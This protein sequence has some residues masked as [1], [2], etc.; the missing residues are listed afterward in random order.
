M[1]AEK[2]SENNGPEDPKLLNA[3]ALARCL[4][5]SVRQAHR[6]N[7]AG[8]VPTPL[9]IGRCVRWRSDEISRWLQ[10]GAPSRERWEIMCAEKQ[11]TTIGVEDRG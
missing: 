2:V 7:R 3:S 10:C 8:L 11:A 6:M 9:R 4:S 5:V 1:I